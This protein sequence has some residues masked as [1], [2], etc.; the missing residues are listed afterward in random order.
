MT[1]RLHRLQRHATYWTCARAIL[2]DLGM[3]GTRVFAGRAGLSHSFRNVRRPTSVALR[4][5]FELREA[6][7]AAEMVGLAAKC[8]CARGWADSDRHAADWIS[9]NCVMIRVAAVILHLRH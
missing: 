5:G 1:R 6:I 3:H 8:V 2:N 7:G 9:C 4:I